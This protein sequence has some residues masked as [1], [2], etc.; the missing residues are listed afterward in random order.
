VDT[1]EEDRD[2]LDALVVLEEPTFPGC[3]V[4]CR[5]I[6]MF[7]MEDEKGPDNKIL[8]V[9]T[10][11]ERQDLDQVS[12]FL[13]SSVRHFFD[14]YRDIEADKFTKVARR[15]GRETAEA[16]VR[17]AQERHCT[18]SRAEELGPA[19]LLNQHTSGCATPGAQGRPR[20]RATWTRSA[21]SGA[22]CAGPAPPSWSGPPAWPASRR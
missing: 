18:R 20:A 12:E 13:R 22:G 11:D 6:G 1:L 16:E 4:T 7:A 2:P 3:H 21:A 5:P 8:A 14:M 17:R 9:P 15:L 19:R 10:W